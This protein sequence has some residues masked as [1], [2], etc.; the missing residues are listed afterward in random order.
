MVSLAKTAKQMGPPVFEEAPSSLEDELLNAEVA[1]KKV[2]TNN[3]R[4]VSR[5]RRQLQLTEKDRVAQPSETV[6]A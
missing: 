1:A 5:R 3:A 2:Q 6:F 4:K